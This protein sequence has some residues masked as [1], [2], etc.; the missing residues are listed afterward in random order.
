MPRVA[1]T[2]SIAVGVGFG[3]V[4]DEASAGGGDVV[5]VPLWVSATAP[6]E[7]SADGSGDRLGGSTL[8]PLVADGSA[9]ADGWLAPLEGAL[10]VGA[11]VGGRRVGMGT[12]VLCGVG[13]GVGPT[14]SETFRT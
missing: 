4:V 7:S 13:V 2:T 10:F 8:D 1:L 12:E 9:A 6:G 11:G 14:S 5:G 3:V